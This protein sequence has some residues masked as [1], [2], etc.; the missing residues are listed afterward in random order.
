MREAKYDSWRGH[1][2]G[3]DNISD[4]ARLQ[5][6]LAKGPQQPID[7]LQTS[8]EQYTKMASDIMEE[9]LKFHFPWLDSTGSSRATWEDW[10]MVKPIVK[11]TQVKFALESFEPYN[12]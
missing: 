6:I 10:L 3:I 7:S 9:L 12:V 5:Q 4:S 8:T 2:E 1:C 11:A